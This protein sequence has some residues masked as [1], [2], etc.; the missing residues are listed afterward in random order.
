MLE[1]TLLITLRTLVAFQP[2]PL[3]G[4][5]VPAVARPFIDPSPLRRP[6]THKSSLWQEATNAYLKFQGAD[7][8]SYP[9]VG[10]PKF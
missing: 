1:S 8:I 9:E 3:A 5:L 2:G 7:P 6:G 10:K 4:E